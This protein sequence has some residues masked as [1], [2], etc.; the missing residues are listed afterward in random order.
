MILNIH[1]DIEKESPR[2]RQA[3]SLD[4]ATGSSK[5]VI[6]RFVKAFLCRLYFSWLCCH[7][8]QLNLNIYNFN[9]VTLAKAFLRSFWQSIRHGKDHQIAT[10]LGPWFCLALERDSNWAMGIAVI[11]MPKTVLYIWI[12]SELSYL[13][14]DLCH[15][16]QRKI[17]PLSQNHTYLPLNFELTKREMVFTA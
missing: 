10:C 11:Q 4:S 3:V 14:P 17:I 13:Y 12:P 9:M 5:P 6:N 16:V 7:I 1:V 8:I 15:G 2:G